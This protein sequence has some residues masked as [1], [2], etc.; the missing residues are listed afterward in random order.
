MDNTIQVASDENSNYGGKNLSS[1]V[2]IVVL[3][4]M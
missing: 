3:P 1:K 4:A 2:E